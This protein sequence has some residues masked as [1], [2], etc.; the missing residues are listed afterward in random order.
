MVDLVQ[1]RGDVR[2]RHLARER[3]G[4]QVL[5]HRQMLEAMPA[6]HH[7]AHAHPHQLVGRQLVDALA[8]ELDRALG[9]V[10]ALGRQQVGDRLER[11]AL[12]R[13]VGAE[14]R[15]DLALRHFQR[16]A[17]QHEDDVV[18]DHLD[19]VH[20]EIGRRGLRLQCGGGGGGGS[21]HGTVILSGLPPP[22]PQ[23]GRGRVCVTSPIRDGSRG[24]VA[25]ISLPCRSRAA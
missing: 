23:R 25:T 5:L 4:Q 8:L 22:L 7:L 21:R 1:R 18:V 3:A 6:F 13:A 12:A 14:Q 9:H 19:V 17:L 10:A 15:D 2:A 16:H 24:T 11:R 20:R